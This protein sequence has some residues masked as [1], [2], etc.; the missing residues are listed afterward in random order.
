MGGQ[1]AR[2]R[3]VAQHHGQ[4][5]PAAS[6]WSTGSHRCRRW[7]GTPGEQFF[8][9]RKGP[10][11]KAGRSYW[12]VAS[13]QS[14]VF[15]DPVWTFAKTGNMVTT[16]SNGVWQTAGDGAALTLRVDAHPVKTSD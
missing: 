13:S 2:T 14:P 5:C 16:T 6:S 8:V 11:I 1:P 4:P 15:V 12:V 10:H 3:R 7:A 9:T